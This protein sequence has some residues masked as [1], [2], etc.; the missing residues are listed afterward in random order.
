[1]KPVAL[2]A[3]G[4]A[5]IGIGAGCDEPA[6]APVQATVV[7]RT[8]AERGAQLFA[9]PRTS[10]Y[11]FNVYACS[12][13]HDSAARGDVIR[14]GVPLAGAAVRP[15]YWGGS[16][17]DLVRAVDHCLELFMLEDAPWTGDEDV[18]Q[19]LY[20]YLEALPAAGADREAQT[21]TFVVDIANAPPGDAARGEAVY[22]RTCATCHGA[23]H[24]GVSKLVD[25]APVLPEE[26]LDAHPLGKYTPLQRRLVILEKIRH[27][28]FLGYGGQMPPFSREELS[29]SDLGDLL[30]MFGI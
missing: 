5:S 25:F 20:A 3:L 9:D 21:Y 19:S 4:A 7:D 13:C 28:G 10:T 16:E 1:M 23:S 18:A 15:T 26:A 14:A 30:A 6:P 27:G 22:G 24:T 12:T 2:L 17:I 11:P 8:A 29:D